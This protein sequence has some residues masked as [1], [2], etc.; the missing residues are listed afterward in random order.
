MDCPSCSHHSAYT[1]LQWIHCINQE[2]RYYDARY[3]AKVE[4]E[5]ADAF[6]TAVEKL[7]LLGGE[8][9]ELDD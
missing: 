3:A 5:R 8:T 9:L 7:I 1:G 4:R 2:C 6:N